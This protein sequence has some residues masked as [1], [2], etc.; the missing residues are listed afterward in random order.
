MRSNWWRLPTCSTFL[1]RHLT[2]S[3]ILSSVISAPRFLQERAVLNSN[4]NSN[5]KDGH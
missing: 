4:S 3:N 1:I 5:F 2:S